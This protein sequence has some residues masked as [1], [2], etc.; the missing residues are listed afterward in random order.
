M[1]TNHDALREALARTTRLLKDGDTLGASLA[2]S[3]V[4]KLFDA[5]SQPMPEASAQKWNRAQ[6]L[7]GKYWDLAYREGRDGINLADEANA[8]LSAF[9]DLFSASPAA[10]EGAKP[11][12]RVAT[13]EELVSQEIHAWRN[14]AQPPHPQ[15]QAQ[16]TPSPD[17][18]HSCGEFCDLP[19]CV[20]AREAQAQGE[21]E[22]PEIVR[23]NPADYCA[24]QHSQL[25]TLQS[26][27]EAMAKLRKELA[28]E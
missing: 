27:R 2:L 14:V 1:N 20:A 11:G 7:L 9:R 8:V 23:C 28:N 6:E 22:E 17:D 3:E 13:A 16:N 25:I 5:L 24:C 21:T 18:I 10:P 26:H 15:P 4:E 19:E 12:D